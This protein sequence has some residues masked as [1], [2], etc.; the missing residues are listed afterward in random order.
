MT[1][2]TTTTDLWCEGKHVLGVQSVAVELTGG[3]DPQHVRGA[4]GQAHL[5]VDP[6]VLVDLHEVA[7]REDLDGIGPCTLHVLDGLRCDAH[8]VEATAELAILCQQNN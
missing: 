5:L 3:D 1:T 8:L 6:Q 7:C 2:T 4:T